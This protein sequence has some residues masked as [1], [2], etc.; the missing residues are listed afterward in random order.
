MTTNGIPSEIKELAERALGV[1]TAAGATYVDARYLSEQSEQIDVQDDRVTGV[2]RGSTAGSRIEVPARLAVEIARSSRA[3]MKGPVRMAGE[4]PHEASWSSPCAIDPFTVPL[5]QKIDLLLAATKA[6]KQVKELTIAEASIDLWRRTSWLATSDGTRIA[7]T[8]THTGAGLRAI[9]IGGGEVQQRS[10]PNSFRGGFASAGWEYAT[11]MDLPGNAPAYAEE[12][13]ALLSA[14]ECPSGTTTLILTPDQLGL[15]VHESIGH[16]IELD[17]VLGMEAA[18]AGTSFLK[19]G[20]E[21]SL[22]YG[23]DLINITA[24]ATLPGGLGTFGWDD[25]GVAAARTPLIEAGMLRAA[26]SDRGSAAA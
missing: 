19:P 25:E 2:G 20:D 26:L 22:R 6:A 1:A 5:D 15:Q 12:A 13:V 24:D 11:A 23:S 9:A 14:P 21:G 3:L 8:I 10:Y 18:Y 17:R 16:P 4:P 7:Q